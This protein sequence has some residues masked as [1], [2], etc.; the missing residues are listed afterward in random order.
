MQLTASPSDSGKRL[1]AFLHERL[2]EFSRSRLQSWIKTN[3]VEVDGQPARPSSLLRGM[4]TISVTPADLP[5]LKAEPEELPLKILYEDPDVIVV[6]KPAGMVVHAGAGHSRGTLVNALLHHFGRLSSVNGDLRPGIVHRLDRETSGVLVVAR[7][8]QAHQALAAQ[9]HGRRV[10]KTYLALVHGKFNQP[11]GRI[12]TPIARDPV[13]RTRM[14]TKLGVGRSAL[15]EYR[16]L[17][18]LDRLSYL[19]VRIGTGRTHQIRVHLASIHHPI[20]GDRL[21]G[22]PASELGRFF[23]HAHR[24]SFQSP[25]TAEWITVESPLP[26]E[27]HAYLNQIRL[28]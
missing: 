28:E 12:T 16:V 11:Q 7:T 13:R 19:E 23:L 27:L 8:D 24:L 14:T 10:E 2:P 21:Y 9:F 3:L 26:P 17:E 20:V 1:D 25:S 6:D 22:A 15:T 18:E 4:E 5:P